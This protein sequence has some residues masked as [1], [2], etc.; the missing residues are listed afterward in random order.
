[1]PHHQHNRFHLPQG[2]GE[3]RTY[4]TTGTIGPLSLWERVRVRGKRPH[5]T[6]NA[7]D[8]KNSPDDTLPAT[9]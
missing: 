2:E 9:G 8:Y 7:S 5:L 1:M 3:N 4:L 6:P